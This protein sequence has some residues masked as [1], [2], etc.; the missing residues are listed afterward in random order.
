MKT[1]FSISRTATFLLGFVGTTDAAISEV[2]PNSLIT[3][4]NNLSPKNG[5]GLQSNTDVSPKQ[6]DEP[7]LQ[8]AYS[9]TKIQEKYRS[10]KLVQDPIRENF[11][12][13]ETTIIDHL[14]VIEG[15]FSHN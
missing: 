3:T 13:N 2:L 1:H 15:T 5:G 6:T 12:S 8:N 10:T 11:L 7:S 9:S 14:P 4:A